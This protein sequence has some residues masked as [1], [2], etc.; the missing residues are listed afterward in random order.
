MGFNVGED[1]IS[2]ASIHV[3]TEE[4]IENLNKEDAKKV[5]FGLLVRYPTLF[6]EREDVFEKMPPK[7]IRKI[8]EKS[9]TKNL[10][11]NTLISEFIIS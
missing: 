7:D 4:I 6:Q 5:V 3:E 8:L 10:R 11:K 2:Y 9:A 1:A